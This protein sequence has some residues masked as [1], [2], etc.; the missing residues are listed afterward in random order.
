M[1]QAE[2]FITFHSIS[3][4][5]ERAVQKEIWQR[6]YILYGIAE[7]STFITPH[8]YPTRVIVLVISWLK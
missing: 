5:L 2:Q 6:S 1:D 3:A 7:V 8:S 4:C